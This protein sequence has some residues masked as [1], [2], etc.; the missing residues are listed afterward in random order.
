MSSQQ[1]HLHSVTPTG[2]G[3]SGDTARQQTRQRATKGL[4]TDRIK[5]E[6]Q[7]DILAAIGRISS[8]RNSINAESLA[9][10]VGGGIAPATVMLSNTFFADANLITIPA[11]GRYAATDALAKYARRL[12]T[13]T[14]DRA[15][16][17]L[18]EPIR[19]S[20]FWQ[21]LEPLFVN[22]KIR[23][24]DAENVLLDAAEA[25]PSHLPMIR[26]MITWL[27][28]IGMITVDDQFIT[29]KGSVLASAPAEDVEVG[30]AATPDGPEK[31]ADAGTE[32]KKPT[33]QAGDRSLAPVISLSFEV[34]ITVDDLA[35]LSAD[36]ITALFA[37][38]GTVA[39]VKGRQ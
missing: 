22:G 15:A 8:P 21:V 4:P 36:Q 18:H 25:S 10:T 27:E 13:D 31:T 7:Y 26:N 17:E 2:G 39:A 38:V 35:R 30:P 37:A 32:S 6:R 11:K 24:S 20:W 16:Q 3:G 23:V 9:R 12:D 19:R 5:M 14:P 28:H 29:A 33:E 1:S 34:R